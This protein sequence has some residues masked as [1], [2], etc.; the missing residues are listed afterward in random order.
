M[1]DTSVGAIPLS[2]CRNCSRKVLLSGE[3]EERFRVAAV[4]T[5]GGREGGREGGRGGGGGGG[6]KRGK[7]QN[8][9]HSLSVPH[10][11]TLTLREGGHGEPEHSGLVQQTGELEGRAAALDSRSDV[12]ADHL[13]RLLPLIQR[14]LGESPLTAMAQEEE[15]GH[16]CDQL[17]IFCL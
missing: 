5:G 11:L 1:T 3:Q 9:T 6:G 12:N 4:F 16:G 10:E 15:G 17:L 7:C 14:E 2:C 8:Q 13:S